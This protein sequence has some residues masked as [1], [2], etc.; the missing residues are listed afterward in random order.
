[1]VTLIT[2][3][4]PTSITWSGSMGIISAFYGTPNDPQI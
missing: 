3:I 1:M 2:Y 4:S